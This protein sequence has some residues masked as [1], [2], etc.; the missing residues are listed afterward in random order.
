M[1]LDCNLSFNTFR[2]SS[3]KFQRVYP[4]LDILSLLNPLLL[5]MYFEFEH[6]N[7]KRMKRVEEKWVKR[8]KEMKT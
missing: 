7:L 1:L 3:E 5:L 6:R 8:T 2:T 4:L